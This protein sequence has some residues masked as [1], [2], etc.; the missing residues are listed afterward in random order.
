MHVTIISS[1]FRRWL[2]DFGRIAMLLVWWVL[3]FD[4]V[5]GVRRYRRC[6]A[7]QANAMKRA[8]I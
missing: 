4:V 6:S 8:Q 2:V 7:Q 1:A 5:P 3:G